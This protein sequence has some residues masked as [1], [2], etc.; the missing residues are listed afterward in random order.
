MQRRIS[1]ALAWT[2]ETGAGSLNST[3]ETD[4]FEIPKGVL[5]RLAS[6]NVDLRAGRG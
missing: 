5:I 6:S 1:D 3:D 2:V 4:G